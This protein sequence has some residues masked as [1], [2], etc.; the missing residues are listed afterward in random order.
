MSYRNRSYSRKGNENVQLARTVVKHFLGSKKLVALNISEMEGGENA[1]DAN[2][3]LV[4]AAFKTVMASKNAKLRNKTRYIYKLKRKL[5]RCYGRNNQ[6]RLIN[7]IA[8]RVK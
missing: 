7:A 6:E 5:K 4:R 2:E 1:M 8:S 3:G